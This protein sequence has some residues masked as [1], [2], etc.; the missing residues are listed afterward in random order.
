M[1]A[2]CK[3]TSSVFYFYHNLLKS[4][5]TSRVTRGGYHIWEQLA[6]SRLL[7]VLLPGVAE[8]SDYIATCYFG[9]WAVY[10]PGDGKFDVENFDPML[11]THGIYGFAGLDESTHKIIALDPYNDLYDNYGKGEWLYACCLPES[12]VKCLR[13][14]LVLLL[15]SMISALHCLFFSRDRSEIILLCQ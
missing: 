7:R 14:C 13:Y 5:T 9:T 3:P 15:Y 1:D 12:V 6:T 10:R 4:A 11:C 2:N 8:S